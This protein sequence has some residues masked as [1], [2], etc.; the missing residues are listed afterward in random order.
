MTPLP[1]TTS[2]EKNATLL[3]SALSL[4]LL[5]NTINNGPT[6]PSIIWILNQN[7]TE[8]RKRNRGMRLRIG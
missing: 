6:I 8:P 5:W 7:G 3:L 2:I 1:A 4:K